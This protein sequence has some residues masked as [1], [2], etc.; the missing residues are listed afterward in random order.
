M[1]TK[2]LLICML[3]ISCETEII[4]SDTTTIFNEQMLTEINF[5]RTDPSAYAELRLKQ[6]NDNGSYLYLKSLL[7]VS[8]VTLNDPLREMALN[9][10]TILKDSLSHYFG[11][12]PMLRAVNAGY[13]GTA[14]GENIAA[15]TSGLFDISINPKQ[16]AI[17]FVK[18][19]I[20]DENVLDLGHRKVIL[21]SKY[22]TV[23]FAYK[24]EPLSKYKN[25]LVQVFGNL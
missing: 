19:L 2:L 6:D 5:A 16:S 15:A 12:S 7:P 23:G 21:S 8:P 11:G 9:Y 14:V 17:E 25:Y 18:I 22:K 24:R 3:L 1:T 4:I 10:V 13:E 20:I